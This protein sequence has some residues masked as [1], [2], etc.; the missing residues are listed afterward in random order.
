MKELTKLLQLRERM[1]KEVN[2]IREQ[3]IQV[4]VAIMLE[5]YALK[6]DKEPQPITD[7]RALELMTEAAQ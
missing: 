5:R 2:L 7:I 3:I 1:V 4:D 6:F